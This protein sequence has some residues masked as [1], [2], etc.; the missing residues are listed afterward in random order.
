M[1]QQL[2]DCHYIQAL[3]DEPGRKRVAKRMPRYTFDSCFSARQSETRLEIDEGFSCFVVIENKLRFLGRLEIP[4]GREQQ[5]C[6][7]EL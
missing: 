3:C 7:T 6:A 2:L 5:F 1:S 4:I